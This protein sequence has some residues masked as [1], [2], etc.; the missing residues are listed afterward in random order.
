MNITSETHSDMTILTVQN[1]R[2]DAAAAIQFKDKVKELTAGVAG[3][4]LLDLAQVAFIDSSGLG[5]IVAAKKHLGDKAPLQLAG[6][7]PI[8]AKVFSLTRME[9]VFK[10]YPCVDDAIDPKERDRA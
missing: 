8:V 9:R 7:T 5:A 3:P 10:I 6:M 2:I 4:V 1:G